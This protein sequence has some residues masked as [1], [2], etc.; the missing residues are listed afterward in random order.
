MNCEV[1]ENSGLNTADAPS[2]ESREPC[3]IRAIHRGLYVDA[4]LFPSCHT[5]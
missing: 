5:L 1:Q 2:R 3:Y 4:R